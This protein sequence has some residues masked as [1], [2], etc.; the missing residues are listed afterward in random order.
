[1][2]PVI[3]QQQYAIAKSAYDRKEFAAA[4]VGFS[5][6]LDVMTDPAAAAAVNQPPLSDLRTLAAGFRDLSMSAATPPPLPTA[7]ASLA[8]AVAPPTLPAPPPPPRIYNAADN[9][10]VPPLIIHQ[11]LPSY[12]G[13]LMMSK[14]GQLEV[15]I[16]ESGAVETAVMTGPVSAQYDA[17]AL[18]A[19]KTWRYRPATINGVAVK[20][21]KAITITVKGRT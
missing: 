16:D 20:F 13:Q 17:Q 14:Q 7:T 6:L 15:I 2:L 19:T 12:Q 5:R 4:S 9:T 1:M 11:E 3:I 8:V 18:A 10:V 21:R